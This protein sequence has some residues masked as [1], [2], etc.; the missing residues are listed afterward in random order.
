MSEYFPKRK[1][2]GG[3]VDIELDLSNYGIKSDSKMRQ[4]L[5]HENLQKKLI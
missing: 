1:L 2:S 4:T 3:I 5:I